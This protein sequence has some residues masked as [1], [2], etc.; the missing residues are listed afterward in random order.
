MERPVI[1]LHAEQSYFLND[2]KVRIKDVC[3]VYCK[4]RHI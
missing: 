1:Y 4:G 3:S 2:P